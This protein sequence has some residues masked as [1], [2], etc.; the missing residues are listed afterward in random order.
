MSAPG[1]SSAATPASERCWECMCPLCSAASRCPTCHG[2]SI[3]AFVRERLGEA[4]E[5]VVRFDD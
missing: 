3:G 5:M 4:D 2:R 1:A